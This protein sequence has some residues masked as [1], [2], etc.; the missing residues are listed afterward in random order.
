[1]DN[2]RGYMCHFRIRAFSLLCFLSDLGRWIF[3]GPGDLFSPLFSFP[4]SFLCWTK[5]RKITFSPQFPLSLVFPR[6]F[7]RTKHSVK[8]WIETRG[9]TLTTTEGGHA[10]PRN[11]KIFTLHILINHI[12]KIWSNS[13]MTLLILK[14]N[15][16]IESCSE[17][18]NHLAHIN[19]E[20]L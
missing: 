9:G 6:L 4:V 12:W 13:Y 3:V 17:G 7:T 10:P 18:L 1:M 2:Q 11:F 19:V 15:S 20:Y 5:R 14:T 8:E 16:K